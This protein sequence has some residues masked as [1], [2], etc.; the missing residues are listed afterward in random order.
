M[1]MYESSAVWEEEEELHPGWDD[2]E[3][4]TSPGT[5]DPRLPIQSLREWTRSQKGNMYKQLRD[6]TQNAL[7]IE[8]EI[9]TRPAQ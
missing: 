5:K 3:K 1:Q 6:D 9:G 4:G 2:H 8:V 7:C